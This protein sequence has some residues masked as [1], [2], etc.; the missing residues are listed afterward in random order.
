MKG[1]LIRYRTAPDRTEE[2]QQLIE[3]VFAELR[4]KSP[5]GP[6]YMVLRLGDGTF[7]H[8]VVPPGEGPNPIPTLEAFKSFQ[9]GVKDRCIDP[10][11][12]SEATLVGN[13]GMLR[14]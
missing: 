2:N 13:Y 9:K 12:S 14:D 11:Q 8:F 1:T 3:K 4:E 6:R 7:V 5:E 10:P